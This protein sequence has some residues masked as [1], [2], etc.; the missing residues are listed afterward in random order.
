MLEKALRRPANQ[1]KDF[2]VDCHNPVT[3]NVVHGAH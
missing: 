3:R 1:A 2:A